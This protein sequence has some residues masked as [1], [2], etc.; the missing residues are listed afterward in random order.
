VDAKTIERWK[1]HVAFERARKAAPVG[2]PTL[3]DIPGGRYWDPEFF[4]LEREA[5]FKR[6]WLYAGHTDQLPTVGSFFV[7]R[8]T[9]TPILIMRGE[10]DRIRAFYNTCRHRGAPLVREQ[11]G[12]ANRSLSCGYHGWT[13]DTMGNLKAVPDPRDWVG[14]NMSCRSLVSVRC[15]RLGNWLFVCEDMDAPSLD[16]F[17][18]PV[19]RYFRHLPLEDLRFVHQ[20]TVEVAGNFKVMLENFLEAYHFRLL[21]RHTTDRIFDNLGTSIHLWEHGHSIMLSPN[22]RPDWVDP[23][24]I[25]MPEMQT[26]TTIERDHNPSYSIFPNIILPIAPTGIPSVFFWPQSVD[27]TLLDVV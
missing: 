23:G 9:G 2:F 14:L 15:E 10:D 13:Y 6:G 20:R 25:G 26:A 8:R 16:S 11:C 1:E 21:H 18:A 12:Q 17:L 27:Q 7:W 3:P 5:L 22:R 4:T 19:S 24:T